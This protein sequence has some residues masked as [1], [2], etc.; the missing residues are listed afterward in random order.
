MRSIILLISIIILFPNFLFSQYYSFSVSNGTYTELEDPV[1]LNNGQVWNVLE[2]G[3]PI[4]FNFPY[5]NSVVDSL[6]FFQDGSSSTLSS[7][8]E[9]GGIHQLFIPF[10]AAL[11]DRGYGTSVS[12]SP[13]SYKLFGLPGNR[14]LK[15]EWKNA[16]FYGELQ[17]NGT[18]SDFINFQMWL[19]E[20]SGN[21]EVHY[22]PSLFN[23]PQFDFTFES[24][25]AVSLIPL[26]NWDQ[27]IFSP[28]SLWLIGNP[29]NP[30][31]I[32]SEDIYF[33]G[34]IIEPNTIY[35]FHNLLVEAVNNLVHVPVVYPNPVFDR[36]N[37]RLNSIY[38]SPVTIIICDISGRNV[39][40]AT[41]NP[42]QEDE[43]QIPVSDLNTGIFQLII[44]QELKTYTSRFVKL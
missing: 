30:E 10:G 2:L 26:Y 37:L 24:G 17:F 3:F 15:I 34:G 28:N 42:N 13:V 23:Y 6:F 39:Y 4:G 1:S 5:F 19:Y 43:I 7:S 16:G 25:P 35:E 8:N 18:T 33:L 31:M 41:T 27:D 9:D 38:T 20:I 36:L 21:I 12:Q 22:G 11:V 32:A 29:T 44:I 40:N 14:V